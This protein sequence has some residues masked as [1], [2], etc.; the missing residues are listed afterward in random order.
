MERARPWPERPGERSEQ[1]REMERSEQEREMERSEQER[2]MERSEQEREME[3]PARGR[4]YDVVGSRA[5]RNRSLTCCRRAA[6][7]SSS[8]G[9]RV[10]K[11][12]IKGAS[13]K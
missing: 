2:E 11:S 9:S 7:A 1:E 4:S 13:L 5:A 3:R 12:A 10:S 6:S 8:R